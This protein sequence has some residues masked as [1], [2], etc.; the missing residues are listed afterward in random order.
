ME[1]VTATGNVQRRQGRI[2]LSCITDKNEIL[3]EP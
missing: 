3:P 2:S 1:L